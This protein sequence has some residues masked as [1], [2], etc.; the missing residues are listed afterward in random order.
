MQSG[1]VAVYD[2]VVVPVM[3]VIEKIAPPPVGKNLLMIARKP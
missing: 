2:R 1:A 3:R